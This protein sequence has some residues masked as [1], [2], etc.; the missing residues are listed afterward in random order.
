[1]QKGSIAVAKQNERPFGVRHVG[2]KMPW[3]AIVSGSPLMARNG[4][5]RRFKT[6]GAARDAAALDAWLRDDA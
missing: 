4:A 3:L 6:E 1:M 2:G 5:E